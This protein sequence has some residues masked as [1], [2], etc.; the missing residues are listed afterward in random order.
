M[1]NTTRLTHLITILSQ[2]DPD[3]FDLRVFYYQT[4]L[5]DTVACAAGYAALDQTFIEQG[6]HLNA[7]RTPQ[8]EDHIGF[9]ALIEFF[10]ITSDQSSYLFS[11]SSYFSDHN[12]QLV[13]DRIK[14]LITPVLAA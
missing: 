1:P 3:Y 4:P 8:Y 11:A 2:I 6:L 14:G 12:P 7:N 13:I 9:D 5:C 10:D